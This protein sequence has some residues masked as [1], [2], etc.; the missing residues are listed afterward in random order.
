LPIGELSFNQS[1]IPLEEKK[2]DMCNHAVP[3]DY[4][5]ILVKYVT[6][7]DKRINIADENL[8]VNEFAPALYYLMSHKEKLKSPSYV[9]YKSG[10]K[11]E[12]GYTSGKCQTISLEA[13]EVTIGVYRTSGDKETSTGNMKI[14]VTEYTNSRVAYQKTNKAAFDRYVDLLDTLK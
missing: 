6:A 3:T 10:F 9:S 12:G 7:E 4:D 14:N 5:R 8:E 1:V 2:L 11:V 13:N